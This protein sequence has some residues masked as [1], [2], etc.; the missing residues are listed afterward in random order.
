MTIPKFNLVD[1]PW[2]PCIDSKGEQVEHGLMDV[3]SNAHKIREV[4]DGSPLITATLHRL[5]IAIL[6]HIL[7][8]PRNFTQWARLWHGGEGSF[9]PDVLR[10][11]FH[12]PSRY[13]AF[14][15]FDPDRPF[16]QSTAAPFYVL[17]SKKGEN[18]P[19]LSPVTRLM[20]ERASGNNDTLFDH[21]VDHAPVPVTPSVAARLLLACHGYAMR[22]RITSINAADASA[23]AGPLVKGAVAI[24]RGETLFQTLMLN[25]HAYDG[26]HGLPFAFSEADDIPPWDRKDCVTARERKLNGYIDLLC[27]QSRS[28]RLMPEID[29][30]GQVRITQVVLLKGEQF[31][32]G[33]H[34][35]RHETMVSFGFNRDASPTQ[36]PF[37]ALGFREDKALWRNSLSLFHSIDQECQ[38][39]MIIDWLNNLAD[40]GHISSDMVLPLDLFGLKSDQAKVLLWRHERLP[41]SLKLVRYP[42]LQISLR[43]AL[44]LAESGREVLRKSAVVFCQSLLMKDLNRRIGTEQQ[45]EINAFAESLG[46]ERRYWGVLESR[47]HS[48]LDELG[49]LDPV[50][51]ASSVNELMQRWQ[52]QIET[53]ASQAFRD[54]I[55]SQGQSAKTLRATVAA[56]RVFFINSRNILRLDSLTENPNGES[57]QQIP[58]STA[59][60]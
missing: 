25:L 41:L 44:R 20:T 17:D 33:F 32:E 49:R 3:L 29:D 47:F 46:I 18:K 43:D 9:D 4:H 59:K 37:P 15:L 7:Q 14:D 52:K 31:P 23:K 38:R 56:Q 57:L 53:T 50:N 11:Y 27:W 48:F 2:I 60:L 16:F 8:G 42:A 40:E 5:L 24:V 13:D 12:S 19:L 28:V 26:A 45:R 58:N 30:N 10:Q 35:F 54:G 36:D 21:S 55:E 51:A 39:P 6:H 22:G 1:Q 34:R